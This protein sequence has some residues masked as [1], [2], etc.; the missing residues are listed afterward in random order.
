MV[1]Y[2]DKNTRLTH[3]SIDCIATKFKKG[4]G[5]LL[6]G[7]GLLFTPLCLAAPDTLKIAYSNVE[8]FPYFL[9]RSHSIP[10]D[11]GISV[12]IILMACK[13]LNIQADLIRLPGKRVLA[14]IKDNKIDGAFLFSYK[15]ERALVSTYP[16]IEGKPNS[17]LKMDTI[18]YFFYKL[19]GSPVNWLDGKLSHVD[20]VG[21]NLG[22]SVISD[23]KKMGLGIKEVQ[24]PMESLQIL[25]NQR[26]PVVVAQEYPFQ[27]YWGAHTDK[28]EKLHPAV[29]TKDYFFIFSREF[30]MENTSFAKQFWLKV[31][32]VRKRE[33]PKLVKK[34]LNLHPKPH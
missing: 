6:A 24:S 18:S 11:P 28:I 19:K 27:R 22:F 21:V 13:E 14:S 15:P 12:E 9:E 34:Y 4:C 17:Y 8:S 2:R 3:A 31:T 7:I 32:D 29:R 23:I 16:M 5:S 10:K 30:F 1:L 20:Y 25:L 26:V 33:Y